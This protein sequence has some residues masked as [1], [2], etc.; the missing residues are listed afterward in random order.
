MQQFYDSY[1]IISNFKI[2]FNLL[3]FREVKWILQS[4]K[5]T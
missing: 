2:V 4:H 5:A 3:R 1:V